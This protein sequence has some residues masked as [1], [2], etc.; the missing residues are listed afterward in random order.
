MNFV[1]THRQLIAWILYGFVLVNG[2]LCS[3]SH[4]QMLASAHSWAV[5]EDNGLSAADICGPEAGPAFS[6][7]E[8]HR[9]GHGLLMQLAMFDCAFAGKLTGALLLLGTMAWLL[10][11][12]DKK[13]HA[14]QG[15]RAS[16]PRH[17]SPGLAPQAP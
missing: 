10:R 15:L 7:S 12:F 16:A 3:V 13:P 8:S 9:G 11:A 17:S 4:G 2:V 5:A 14:L 1:R 6:G